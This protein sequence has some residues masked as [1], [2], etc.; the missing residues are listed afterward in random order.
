MQDSW[1][2]TLLLKV[3]DALKA[4]EMEEDDLTWTN[5][6]WISAYGVTYNFVNTCGKDTKFQLKLL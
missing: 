3:K 4:K 6:N 2:S 1:K 5:H